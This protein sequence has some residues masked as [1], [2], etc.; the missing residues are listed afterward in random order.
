[1]S[2][3]ITKDVDPQPGDQ[4]DDRNGNAE[5]LTTAGSPPESE[6]SDADPRSV[7]SD[8]LEI[9]RAHV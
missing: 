3:G 7:V 5:V 6:Q 2:S 9:G 1:M 8:A 4:D